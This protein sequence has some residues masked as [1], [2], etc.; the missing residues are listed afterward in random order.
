VAWSQPVE[1]LCAHLHRRVRNH[2]YRWPLTY[3]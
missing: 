2:S 1:S 3:F